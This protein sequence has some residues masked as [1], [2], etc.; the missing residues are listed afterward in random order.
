FLGV[1]FAAPPV[2]ALRWE[3]PTPPESWEGFRDVT[4]FSMHCTHFSAAF[5]P[6]LALASPEH[7][8]DCLYLNVWVPQGVDQIE[9]LP[10]M[11]FYYG[12]AFISGT[13][14]LYPGSQLAIQ[15]DVIVVNFNYRLSTLGW[16]SMISNGLIPGDDVLP[17]NLGLWDARAALQWVQQNIAQ[18]GGDPSRV[19][20]FGQSAGGSMVSH[21]VI[22]PQ[23][24]GLF[25]RAIAISGA[26][27]SY[28]SL[29]RQAK[30]SLLMMSEI[31]DCDSTDSQEI[32]DCLRGFDDDLL[33]F[34]GII[35]DVLGRER[36][37]GFLPTIDGEMVLG[38][39]NEMFALG[40]GK[41]I[42]FITGNTHHDAAGFIL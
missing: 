11:V 25:Q 19:T 26:S 16:L 15:G 20:I 14:E 12:G 35:G 8:E 5:Y 40:Y 28:Y 7:G 41:D 27:S 23:F 38:E 42:D 4:T 13:G 39:P 3:K 24:D 10:V 1:P 18:F 36:M 31:F 33:D 37:P 21:S 32:V 6:L 22:S 2:G 30:G 17:G 9:S 29:T 34:W